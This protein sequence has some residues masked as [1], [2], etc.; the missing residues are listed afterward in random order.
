MTLRKEKCTWSVDSAIW[1]GYKFSAQGMPADPEKIK[2]ITSLPHPHKSF[3]QI[4]QYN[5]LFMFE[6]EKTYRDITAPL[7]TLLRK[8]QHFKWTDECEKSLS[9]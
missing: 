7:C 4:C 6:I 3:L 1:F 5:F 9:S 8:D 2:A